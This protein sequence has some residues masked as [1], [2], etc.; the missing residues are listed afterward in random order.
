MPLHTLFLKS[1]MEWLVP[2]SLR[3]FHRRETADFEAA[4]TARHGSATAGGEAAQGRTQPLRQWRL[5]WRRGGGRG[6]YDRW[7]RGRWMPVSASLFV[8]VIIVAVVIE[9]HFCSLLECRGITGWW[10]WGRGGWGWGRRKCGSQW[11]P[12]NSWPGQHRRHADS[13]PRQLLLSHCVC[14]WI[15]VSTELGLNIACRK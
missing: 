2:D 6:G 3:S 8:I 12:F 4:P 15:V 5:W 13:V 11:A 9:P 7:R 14:L 1:W 10:R